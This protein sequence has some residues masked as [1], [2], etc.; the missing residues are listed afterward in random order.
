MDCRRDASSKNHRAKVLS[1]R[2]SQA[3]VLAVSGNRITFPFA[4]CLALTI[5]TVSTAA[6]APELTADEPIEF[7]EK[8]RSMVARGNAELISDEYLIEA[9]SIGF[10]QDDQSAE[11][12]GD[13]RISLA[14]LRILANSV[15]YSLA[16]QTFST[17]AFR[18]G[19]A[20]FYLGGESIR[21][22]ID[23]I[24]IQN[25]TLYFSEPDDYSF[26][27]R[28]DSLSLVDR[29]TA[30]LQGATLRIGN[31]PIFYL[32]NY[33]QDLE[34]GLPLRWRAN[35]GYNSFLGPFIQN[36]IRYRFL[37]E[38]SAG[39]L[40]DG[41]GKQGPLAG[42]TFEVSVVEGPHWIRSEMFSGFIH[43]MGD[44]GNDIIGRPIPKDRFFLEWEHIQAY[45]ERVDITGRV[46]W[47]SDSEA[48]RDFRPE[49]FLDNQQPENFLQ[50]AYRG[51]YF[52]ISAFARPRVNDWQLVQERLPEV[53]FDLMPV[54][55]LEAT[56]T[57][58]T[59]D[60][61]FVRLR[62]KDPFAGTELDSNRVDS[63][64]GLLQPITLT[65]WATVTPVAGVRTTYYENTVNNQGSYTR[66]LGQAGFDARMSITGTWEYKNEFWGINGLRH[67]LNPVL[68]YRYIPAAQYGRNT[69]PQIE[70]DPFVTYMPVIDLQELRNL[71]DLY[72]RNIV[73]FGFE[74]T[75]ETR[76]PTYG[77]RVLAEFNIFQDYLFSA[78]PQTGVAGSAVNP[79]HQGE[80]D[81][82][83]LYANMRIAPAYWLDFTFFSRVAVSGL[84][85]REVHSRTRIRDGERW[86]VALW[87]AFQES[88]FDQY[89]L[90]GKYR[91]TERY[92]GRARYRFDAR[93]GQLVE[94]IYAL[95]TYLGNS[96][97]LEYYVAHRIGSSRG[98]DLQFG[99]RVDL[100][101]F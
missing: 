29:N 95:T 97:A 70:R 45:G 11:A 73:R 64:I 86:E 81:W 44:T 84:D 93:K 99:V 61:A 80:R 16:D 43:S 3:I 23:N 38:L 75:L 24:S 19:Q 67:S 58:L 59:A 90:E 41:Y 4:I 79:P 98:D 40:L 14:T 101:Q 27:I 66:V 94:Q 46:S 21:G 48:L 83:D 77:S 28:A 88:Q 100:M 53:R 50:G 68:Q 8:T 56:D 91:F 71:D 39:V 47:W 51:D 35:I 7:D 92:Q 33:E 22:T 31:V 69:I 82:S 49:Y 62:E 52:I 54:R 65:N 12:I 1:R 63:Y 26:N 30:I 85:L 89:A 72:E 57:Y 32:S 55:V 34:E 36:T 42:P 18:L 13:V 37:P 20:P 15:D 25:G 17:D 96:W 10:R 76:D 78:R 5:A 60:L 2:W 9:D 6:N 87:T 74:N